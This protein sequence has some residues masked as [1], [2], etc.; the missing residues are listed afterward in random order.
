[1]SCNESEQR[2]YFID[3]RETNLGAGS[4]SS[5]IRTEPELSICDAIAEAIHTD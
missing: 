3:F 4:L 1:L 2:I 5:F